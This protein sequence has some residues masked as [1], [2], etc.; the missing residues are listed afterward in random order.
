[1]TAFEKKQNKISVYIVQSIFGF[2]YL[3][4]IRVAKK[5]VEFLH[6]ILQKNPS[7]LFGQTNM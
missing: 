4:P 1:M 2:I 3:I 5:F 7:E 6:K